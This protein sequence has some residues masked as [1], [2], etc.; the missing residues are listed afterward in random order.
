MCAGSRAHQ[1]HHQLH[2][3]HVRER[4]LDLAQLHAETAQLDLH[5]S[6][7]PWLMAA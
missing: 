2:A 1:D 6:G 4:V 5:A 3:G 7:Q